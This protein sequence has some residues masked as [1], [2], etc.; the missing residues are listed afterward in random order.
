MSNLKLSPQAIGAIMFSMQNGIK[1]AVT[2]VGEADISK[3]IGELEFE[4]T[5]DGLI[6]KNPPIMDVDYF[7]KV[8][9]DL[10]EMEVELDE[11]EL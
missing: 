3:Q 6:V 1:A 10:E 2:G 8:E 4:P 9:E 5:A 7:N 11:E